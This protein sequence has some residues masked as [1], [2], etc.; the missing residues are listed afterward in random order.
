MAVTHSF[1]REQLPRFYR[2]SRGDD[3]GML[4]PTPIDDC[5]DDRSGTV[6]LRLDGLKTVHE[7]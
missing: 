5:G 6:F 2:K 3:Y 1:R 4:R 7:V